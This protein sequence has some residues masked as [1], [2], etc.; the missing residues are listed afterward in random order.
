MAPGVEEVPE[1]PLSPLSLVRWAAAEKARAVAA[2]FPQAL[3][4]GA[5]TEV[6]LRGRALGKPRDRN[7]ARRMLRELSGRTHLVYT[8]LHVIN[9]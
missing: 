3:V 5:D 8:A 1:R 4:I 7:D 9:G 2:R 6:V